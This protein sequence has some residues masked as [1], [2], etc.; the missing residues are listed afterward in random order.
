[1]LG[2]CAD[3]GAAEGLGA[4]ESRRPMFQLQFMF[5]GLALRQ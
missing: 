4:R 3:W 2:R 5:D 1:M